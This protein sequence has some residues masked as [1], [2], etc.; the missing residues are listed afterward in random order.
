MAKVYEN[1]KGFKVIQATRGEMMC[2]LSEY[3]CAGICDSCG[4]MVVLGSV[5][6]AV[7]APV[8]MVSTLLFLIAGTAPIASM[9]GMP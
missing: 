1:K 8:M 4:S 2:A 6:V 5:I 7:L 3:G 9:N